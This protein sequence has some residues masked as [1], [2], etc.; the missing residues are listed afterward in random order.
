MRILLLPIFIL[1]STL[2]ISQTSSK[3][4]IGTD[5]PKSSLDINSNTL[6]FIPPRIALENVFDS[7]TVQNKFNTQVTVPDGTFVYNTTTNLS[8]IS[9]SYTR[10]IP[11]LYV[12]KNKRWRRV[13]NGTTKVV[14]DE[15]GQNGPRFE[16][17]SCSDWIEIQSNWGNNNNVVERNS[18]KEAHFDF[19][20]LENSVCQ[21]ELFIHIESRD[22]RNIELFLISPTGQ[23]LELMHGNGP[24]ISG[25]DRKLNGNF[26]DQATNLISAWNSGNYNNMNF[27]PQGLLSVPNY[28]NHYTSGNI[29]NLAG[30]N[31]HNPQGKW[32][33]I[34][35]NQSSA[36]NVHVF[37]L[38]LRLK[39]KEHYNIDSSYKLISQIEYNSKT[40]KN[41]VFN[42]SFN[43]LVQSNVL[44]TVV[45]R[46]LTPIDP[47]LTPNSLSTLEIRDVRTTMNNGQ[48]WLQLNNQ[49]IDANMNL[50]TT[51][52]YQLWYR[53]DVLGNNKQHNVT[54]NG[55]SE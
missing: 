10:L 54:I 36:D 53:G 47:Y 3:V 9:D 6:G 50:N 33:F 34:I 26:S 21:V 55:Y 14:A 5:A 4:G 52:Y 7:I 32:H 37:G 22:M 39:V 45:T 49:D 30:F 31:S 35:N 13:L 15:N 11:G 48:S 51:Y 23:I 38:S 17:A 16:A 18:I 20:G 46:S 44:H 12:W 42:S 27:K 29:P 2:A 1:I 25:G 40:A 43:A 24:I 19:N 41:A 8:T 28:E